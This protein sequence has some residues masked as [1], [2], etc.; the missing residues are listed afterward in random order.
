MKAIIDQGIRKFWGV[1]LLLGLVLA[2]LQALAVNPQERVS[3]MQ[4]LM[5]E[6]PV[7]ANLIT[8]AGLTPILSDNTPYTILAPSEAELKSL[9][10][11]PPVRLRAV[12]AGHII[13]GQYRE[14]D[15]KDGANIET[16][17]STKVNVCRK[18]NYTL[19]DGVKIEKADI[20]VNNSMLHNMA[21]RLNI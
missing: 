4:Y 21:G 12:L 7:L 6:R 18:K 14:T 13:K 16:L 3:L 15:F 10:N 20:Q 19:L 8:K 9:E 11:L 1:A 2:Q 17:A 5:K